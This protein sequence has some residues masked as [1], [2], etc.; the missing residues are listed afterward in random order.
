M[1]G[2]AKPPRPSDTPPMLGGAKP[3]RPSDTPPMLGGA[4]AAMPL[5]NEC[6]EKGLLSEACVAKG[7][8]PLLII[9]VFMGF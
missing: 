4:K 7:H 2:G 8:A 5:R 6:D 9:V 3:P 1:L